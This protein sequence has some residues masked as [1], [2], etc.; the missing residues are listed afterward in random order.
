MIVSEIMSFLNFIQQNIVQKL[1]S[2]PHMYS[3]VKSV[4]VNF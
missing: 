1:T 3:I 2:L 4:D